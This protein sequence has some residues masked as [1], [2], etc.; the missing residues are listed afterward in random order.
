M[1]DVG[2][3]DTVSQRRTRLKNGPKLSTCGYGGGKTHILRVK[4]ER[5]RSPPSRDGVAG[6]S[7]ELIFQRLGSLPNGLNG[8]SCPREA[9][10]LSTETG[11]EDPFLG[12]TAKSY[13]R[14][15]ATEKWSQ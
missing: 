3:D 7:I 5:G 11:N 8:P 2:P 14:A 15:M 13:A 6:D 1:S 10:R 12:D 4:V 9:L